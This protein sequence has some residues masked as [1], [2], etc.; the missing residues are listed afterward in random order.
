MSHGV[1][2]RSLF[3]S[4]HAGFGTMSIGRVTS[5]Q[6]GGAYKSSDDLL[7]EAHSQGLLEQIINSSTLAATEIPPTELIQA[8]IEKLIVNAIINPLSAIFNRKNGQLFNHPAIAYLMQL[9][10]SEASL[11]ARSLPELQPLPNINSR[12]SMH[13]LQNVVRDVAEKTGSNTSSMLQDVMA[14]R[15]TEINYIN[16]YIIGRGAQL[17]ISC[18]HHRRV[19][20]MVK[21]RRFVTEE[22]V[23]EGFP[24]VGD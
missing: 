8:Q 19:V 4:V 16:G 14:G 12:F 10:L 3:S 18:P 1:Y 23:G 17:Q 7:D 6:N 21:D 11:V 2:K 24:L 22:Q 5:T 20:Q 15:E 9:L 13:R